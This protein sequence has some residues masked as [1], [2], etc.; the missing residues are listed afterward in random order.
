MCCSAIDHACRRFL[1]SIAPQPYHT[2]AWKGAGCGMSK[3]THILRTKRHATMKKTFS[4]SLSHTHTHAHYKTCAHAFIPKHNNDASS[5]TAFL[6]RFL[7]QQAVNNNQEKN[8]LPAVPSAKLTGCFRPYFT[9][10]AII[11]DAAQCLRR[12]QNCHSYRSHMH[13]S[14]KTAVQ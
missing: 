1:R 4:L 13:A 14:I 5:A 9:V 3:T 6:R 7:P 12:R 2:S 11:H 8:K 10:D